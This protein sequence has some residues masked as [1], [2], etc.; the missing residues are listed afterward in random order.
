[1]KSNMRTATRQKAARDQRASLMQTFTHMKIHVI[2]KRHL[3]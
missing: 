3:S 2:Q 1:M